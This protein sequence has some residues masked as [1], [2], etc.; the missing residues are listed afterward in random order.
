MWEFSRH[1]L[2]GWPRAAKAYVDDGAKKP[3]LFVVMD[4]TDPP[5]DVRFWPR[6]AIQVPLGSPDRREGKGAGSIFLFSEEKCAGNE[7]RPGT[8][9]VEMLALLEGRFAA[10]AGVA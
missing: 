6:R 2:F 9:T 5:Y 4:S 10:D 7:N 8:F 3:S 1:C